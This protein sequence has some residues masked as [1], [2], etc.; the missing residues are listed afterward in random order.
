M[1]GQYTTTQQLL[2]SN[3]MTDVMPS[4]TDINT[5]NIDKEAFSKELNKASKNYTDKS[6]VENKANKHTDYS[7]QLKIFTTTKKMR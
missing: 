3:M 2:P 4:K 6:E 1:A 5:K 7:K